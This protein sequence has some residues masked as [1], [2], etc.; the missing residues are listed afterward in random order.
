MYRNK[1][2]WEIRQLKIAKKCFPQNGFF[3]DVGAYVGNHSVYAAK[4]FG[5]K[6][7]Y[8]FEPQEAIIP[9]LKKNISINRID[10][11][12]EFFPVALTEHV[13]K[14]S[15]S[16]IL[17]GT[18]SGTAYGCDACGKTLGIPLDA[19]EIPC[20]DMLKIDVEGEEISVLRGAVKTI[21][22]AHPII[23]LEHATVVLESDPEINPDEKFD[24]VSLEYAFIDKRIREELIF[25][26]SEGQRYCGL[27]YNTIEQSLVDVSGVP[28]D[29][30]L[31]EVIAYPEN[32]WNELKADWESHNGYEDDPKGRE[33]NLKRK[34]AVKITYQTEYWF[35]IA[36]FY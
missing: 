31:V 27:D 35:N 19:Y 30:I 7:I 18:S 28:H 15:I 24:G 12:I 6:K 34:E 25:A 16:R 10:D 32:A 36:D 1:T 20:V 26:R 3:V 4:F 14:M 17:P 13:Q 29:R 11:K 5:A 23:W 21:Q 22:R 2:F 33:E 8:A 9:I